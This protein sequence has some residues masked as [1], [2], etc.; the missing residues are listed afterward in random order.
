MH[1]LVTAMAATVC[2]ADMG[3]LLASISAST[4][5]VAGFTSALDLLALMSSVRWHGATGLVIAVHWL[6]IHSLICPT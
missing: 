4:T 6:A 3:A 1:E 5:A 2:R